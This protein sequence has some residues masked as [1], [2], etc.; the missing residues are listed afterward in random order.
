M[1]PFIQS[2]PAIATLGAALITGFGA[3]AMKHRW[4]VGAERV[5]WVRESQSRAAERRLRAFSAYLAGRPSLATIQHRV[6]GARQGEVVDLDSVRR[7]F[8]L[9]A[10]RLLILLNDPKHQAIVESDQSMVEDWILEVSQRIDHLAGCAEV[11]TPHSILELAR[12]LR[13]ACDA[14]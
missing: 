11:E 1:N 9:E 12:E 14:P 7:G 5:R 2:L 13:L 8:R 3:A 4:D 6:F 10:A